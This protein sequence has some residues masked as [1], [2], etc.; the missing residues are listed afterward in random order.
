MGI[1]PIRFLIEDVSL[2]SI[3]IHPH[4]GSSDGIFFRD[5]AR[6]EGNRAMHHAPAHASCTVQAC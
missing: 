6:G 4:N 3:R 1:G 2:L 5:S